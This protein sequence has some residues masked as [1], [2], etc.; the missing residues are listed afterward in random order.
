[1][2]S[3]MD[4]IRTWRGPTPA[5]VMLAALAALVLAVG[6]C[7]EFSG[8]RSDDGQ[9][10]SRSSGPGMVAKTPSPI[11]DVPMPVG[12]VAVAGRSSSFVTP[13]GVR[14]VTHTYQ[15]LA[16]VDEAVRFY[17]RQL[18]LHGWTAVSEKMTGGVAT[19]V[20]EK[21]PERLT[22]EV[23]EPRVLEIVVEIRDKD[24]PATTP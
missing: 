6:G 11:P 17:R 4:A 21:G 14:M 24:L 18:P 12:F 1:M 19:L 20:C 9:W 23:S 3:R 8:Y 10:L 22:V 2:S 13:A 16:E 15:G 7:G 5:A